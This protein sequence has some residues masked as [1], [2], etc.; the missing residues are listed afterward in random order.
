MHR[1]APAGRKSLIL[2]LWLSM[3]GIGQYLTH[4]TARLAESAGFSTLSLGIAGGMLAAATVL[5][6][7]AWGWRPLRLA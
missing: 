6:L 2:G 7:I 1:L 3:L 4:Q 5:A